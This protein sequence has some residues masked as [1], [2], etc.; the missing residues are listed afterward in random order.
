[1]LLVSTRFRGLDAGVFGVVE[2]S[3]A[4]AHH[5]AGRL[6]LMRA[7]N[8]LVPEDLDDLC[9]DSSR[10]PEAA[11]TDSTDGRTNSTD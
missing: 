1:V 7:F 3:R 4:R 8:D 2:D 11:R 5:F 10:W 6:E 9:A